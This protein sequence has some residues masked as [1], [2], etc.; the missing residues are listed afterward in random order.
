[1]KV[2]NLLVTGNTGGIETLCRSIALTQKEI[3]NR[4]MFIFSGGIIATQMQEMLGEKVVILNKKKNF[5]KIINEITKYCKENKIDIIT[6]H[7]GGLYTNLIYIALKK[8]NRKIKFVRYLHSCYEEREKISFKGQI[9]KIVLQNALNISNLIICVSNAVK[10]T[11]LEKLNIKNKNITVIYNGIDEK[12]FSL[13]RKANINNDDINLIY[14]GRLE[15]VKGL[16]ILIEA[17]EEVKLKYNNLK[18]TVIGEGKEKENLKQLAI[19]KKVDKLIS[20]EGKKIEIIEWLDKSNI[21][22]YP[23]RWEEAFGISVVESMARGLIPITFKKGGL[24]EIVVD[25]K[26]G[27]LVKEVDSKELANTIMKVIELNEK[28]KEEIITNAIMTA[29]KFK[30]ENTIR[31]IDEEY[32]KI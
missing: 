13:E 3:D 26:N 20:F 1:M 19:E 9:N 2:L 23:I 24:T 22:I 14:V 28:D 30:I 25:Q 6:I 17:L 5:L 18:L 29:N 11:H 16:D 27:F 8:K 32:K 10:N 4:W 15:K 7:H 12:F 21:F 31:R